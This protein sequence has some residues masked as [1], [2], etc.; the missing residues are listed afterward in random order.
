LQYAFERLFSVARAACTQF[1]RT[2]RGDLIQRSS[3]IS[4]PPLLS[5]VKFL[6]FGRR[7]LDFFGPD[8]SPGDAIERFGDHAPDLLF[9]MG[10]QFF[11]S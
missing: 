11:W 7:V 5:L 3:V 4:F 6:S 9:A 10:L 1:S 2:G 8:F